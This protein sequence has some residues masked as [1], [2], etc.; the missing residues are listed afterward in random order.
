MWYNFS[1]ILSYKKPL[2][3]VNGIRGHGKTYG[4]KKLA[5]KGFEARQEEFVYVRRYDTQL[6]LSKTGFLKDIWKDNAL[7]NLYEVQGNKLVMIGKKGDEGKSISTPTVTGHFIPLSRYET[8]KSTSF[9]NVGTLI[10]DEFITAEQYLK[11]EY[12][13]FAD[14]CE[15]V[16]RHRKAR[17]IMLSNSLSVD[18]PYYAEWGIKK[19]TKEFT[20]FPNMVIHRDSNEEFSDFKKQTAIGKIF[21]DSKWG[22]YAFDNEYALDDPTFIGE[23]QGTRETLY[24]LALHDMLIGIYY[25]NGGLYCGKPFDGAIFTPYVEDICKFNNVKLLDKKDSRIYNIY[26]WGTQHKLLFADQSTKNEIME[27]IS[28]IGHNY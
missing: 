7:K 11:D 21:G 12:F 23:P 22:A 8:Y 27:L 28:R 1:P 14:L 18:N 2:S 9:E 20:V 6:Q 15:T 17:I 24:N 25:C 4:A 19:L 16:F 10:F 5:F 26:K 3:I 13:K